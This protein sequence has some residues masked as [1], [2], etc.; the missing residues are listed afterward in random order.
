MKKNMGS[1]I[2]HRKHSY[3]KGVAYGRLVLTGRNFLKALYGQ[4]RR[5]V[6]A[7]CV[8]GVTKWY[9]F[10]H[11]VK[12]ETKSCGCLQKELLAKRRT[13]HGMRN[14]PLY[15]VYRG[16]MERCYDKRNI[17]Y[18]DYG[19]RGIRVCEEWRLSPKDFFDWAIENGWQHGLE[20]D[21]REN[22]GNYGPSNCRFLTPSANCRNRRN[23]RMITA[24]GQTKC[25]TEWADDPRC[26]ISFKRLWARLTESGWNSIEEMITTPPIE[27]KEAAR[28]SKSVRMITAFGETKC[29]AAWLEDE[30]CKVKSAA[31]RKRLRKGWSAEAAISEEICAGNF[32]INKDRNTRLSP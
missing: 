10:D 29:L 8:C 14:H 24:F 1:V 16:M 28:S 2:K 22:D 11:L 25:L 31:L 17:G 26:K 18:P 7:D 32:K 15:H 12:G 9:L 20:L 4:Q 19:Q 13:I 30:R 27:M 6:E 21:R 3:Q 5:V 23:N